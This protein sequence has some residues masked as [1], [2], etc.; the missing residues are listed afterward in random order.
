LQQLKS[1]E[2]ESGNWPGSEFSDVIA[3]VQRIE[4]ELSCLLLPSLAP[5]AQ[6]QE[7]DYQLAYQYILS[8][9]G[10]DSAPSA[11]EYISCL[12]SHN[13]GVPW[14]RVI[15]DC[16][17]YLQAI[18]H[19][20]AKHV[21]VLFKPQSTHLPR[22]YTPVKRRVS[23]DDVIHNLKVGRFEEAP[24]I[25]VSSPSHNDARPSPQPQYHSDSMVAV[26]EPS[27]SKAQQQHRPE[28]QFQAPFAAEK[29]E[30]QSFIAQLKEWEKM[31]SVASAV[32]LEHVGYSEVDELSVHKHQ[33]ETS[34]PTVGLAEMSLSETLAVRSSGIHAHH[35]CAYTGSAATT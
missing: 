28:S 19:G 32:P 27:S 16:T 17:V 31:S 5:N 6:S 22:I 24:A 23:N 35:S 8:V 9:C 15:H 3:D 18:L 33:G 25:V 30:H 10:P 13:Q 7:A 14:H 12:A 11:Q 26:S 29:Q 4:K 1:G 2:Q 20:S 34:V 21:I